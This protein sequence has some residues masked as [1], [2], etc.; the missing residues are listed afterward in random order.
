MFATVIKGRSRRHWKENVYKLLFAIV[1]SSKTWK[2]KWWKVKIGLDSYVRGKSGAGGDK[3]LECPFTL[4]SLCKRGNLWNC[5]FLTECVSTLLPFGKNLHWA[6]WK[7]LMRFCWWQAHK[8][9]YEMFLD[10]NA[11]TNSDVN[12]NFWCSKLRNPCL[13]WSNMCG[14][15]C[16][17]EK[18]DKQGAPV[19]WHSVSVLTQCLTS[20]LK[21]RF[22]FWNWS[23]KKEKTG[24]RQCADTV[25]WLPFSVTLSC[26][27]WFVIWLLDI[28]CG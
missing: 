28:Q 26:T 25:P 6:A 2:G 23:G 22:N 24:G 21:N 12:L 16:R 19:C 8:Q 27:L 5:A 4:L 3:K 7:L 20:L 17:S 11:L 14:N 13:H 15:G 10:Y 18:K 1:S 9:K